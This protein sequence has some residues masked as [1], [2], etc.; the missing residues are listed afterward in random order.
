MFRW[1]D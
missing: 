1:F